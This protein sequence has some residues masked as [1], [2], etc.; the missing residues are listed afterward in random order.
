[1][2]DHLAIRDYENLLFGGTGDK[3]GGSAVQL[4]VVSQ[5]LKG[6]VAEVIPVPHKGGKLNGIEAGVVFEVSIR[7]SPFSK[8]NLA[9][10]T[11]EALLALHYTL[12]GLGRRSR[13][14]FGAFQ[15][16]P[17]PD[18]LHRET[19]QDHIKTSV[20]HAL[21]I[22]K[23]FID[24]NSTK[25]YAPASTSPT[26]RSAFPV[27]HSD[28]ACIQVGDP[29]PSSDFLKQTS[30]NQNLI[31]NIHLEKHAGLLKENV[32]GKVQGGRQASTMCIT[33]LQLDDKKTVPVFTQFYCDTR[34]HPH[35]SDFNEIYLFPQRNYNA[36]MIWG[37]KP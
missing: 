35:R 17:A 8:A 14:A 29:H 22:V 15:P 30:S 9:C 34:D 13:R 21:T 25:P 6:K 28:V 23:N 26:T 31:W 2:R 12:G 36:T 33:L 24:K 1:M 10:E 32:L 19:V 7:A 20:H 18:K 3:E 16:Y 4:R 37:C 11:I 27:L 5:S